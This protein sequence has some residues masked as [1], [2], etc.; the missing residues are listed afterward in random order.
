MAPV[1]VAVSTGQML[2]VALLVSGE[3]APHT[4][5]LL[6]LFFFLPIGIL[7]KLVYLCCCCR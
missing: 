7:A 1:L 5:G 2:P 6:V 4:Y 3:H